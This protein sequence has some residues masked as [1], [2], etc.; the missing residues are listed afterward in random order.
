MPMLDVCLTLQFNL[1]M[2]SHCKAMT[3]CSR[4]KQ[5]HTPA[6][7]AHMPARRSREPLVRGS[8]GPR[9]HRP[10]DPRVQRC[11]SEVTA[12]RNESWLVSHGRTGTG[13]RIETPLVG[14]SLFGSSMKPFVVPEARLLWRSSSGAQLRILCTFSDPVPSPRGRVTPLPQWSLHSSLLWSL[15]IRIIV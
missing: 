13:G 1:I 14:A 9:G 3:L 6:S 7:C 2:I 12:S 4:L 11:V 15:I 5:T 10:G 8:K